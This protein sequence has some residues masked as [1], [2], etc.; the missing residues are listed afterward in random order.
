MLAACEEPKEIGLPPTTPVGV[1][2]TDTL[3]ISRSTVLLDSVRSNGT[4]TLLMGRYT[5]PVFGKVQA[6]AF[7]Q[8]SLETQF[9]VQD[10]SKN[11][12]P[13]AQLV[14]DST[15]LILAYNFA[16][17]DTLKT[18][19]LAV[20]RLTD[21]LVR[22]RNYD[23]R[24]SVA[25]DPEPLTKVQFTPRPAAQAT[26]RISLPAAFGRE[27]LALA[28]KDAGKIDSVF[29]KQIKGLALVPGQT[30]SSM[31]GIPV[32]GT[33]AY[34]AMYY[35]K[36][37][38]T[39]STAQFFTFN[40]NGVRFNQVRADRSGT[41]LAGLQPGQSLPA[42]ATQGQT[43]V[44]PATGVTTKLDFP[45]LLNL[46]QQGRIAINRA[47]LIIT[48]KQPDNSALYIPPYLALAE[49]N[50]QNQILRSSPSGFVQFVTPAS[51]LFDR[52]EQGWVNPQIA[53]YDTRTR[54]YTATD[55]GNR[56]QSIL[57][58]GYLQS[59]LSGLTP[60]RGLVIQTP[61]NSALFS[62]SSGLVN[63][64]QYY[65]ND[66]TWRMVLDGSASVRIVV[67]YTYSN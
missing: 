52:N 23:I 44:Q 59:I 58:G 40:P 14:H 19:E 5:D 10:A 17:G 29:K 48:P 16:Y 34:V 31:L 15:R 50:D 67:F 2:Y 13:D 51:S 36:E 53:T 61:S 33:S 57:L 22:N 6:T 9:V 18:H 64:T 62:T 32:T 60:N 26:Q 45:T 56:T 27:L 20:H 21:D 47:D 8:L 35:H 39:T 38:D 3:T 55:A 41:P 4:G 1:Y 46:R 54:V 30:N 28:N 11:N 66:R 25:Y 37:G 65:L 42:S 7:S 24:S 12:I 63:L 49:V 43:F